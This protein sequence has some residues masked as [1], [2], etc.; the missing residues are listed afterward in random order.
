MRNI[1]KEKDIN[2]FS[3]NYDD[4]NLQKETCDY[5]KKPQFLPIS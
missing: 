5:N 3:Y 4:Q 2:H 1:C